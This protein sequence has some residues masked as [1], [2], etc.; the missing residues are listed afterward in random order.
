LFTMIMNAMV[1]PR[2]ISSESSRLDCVGDGVDDSLSADVRV[3]P[4]CRCSGEGMVMTDLLIPYSAFRAMLRCSLPYARRGALA[5]GGRR[6][7][8]PVLS[9]LPPML[10]H[11]PFR[12]FCNFIQA[13]QEA[14]RARFPALRSTQ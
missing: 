10:L 14:A 2:R 3:A 8:T 13:H 7:S 6:F 5:K 4:P 12:D 9:F 11:S 1:T